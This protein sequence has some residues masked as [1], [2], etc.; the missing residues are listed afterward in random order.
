MSLAQEK[1]PTD[2]IVWQFPTENRFLLE[3]KPE[4]FFQPTISRRLKSGMF[5]FVRTSDPEPARIFE[6]FH[7]GIDIKPLH[8]DDK[9]EPLDV[10]RAVADGVVVRVNEDEK[11]SDYGRQVIVKHLWGEQPV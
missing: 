10:V 9:G 7:K 2:R 1:P 3:E 6:R 4:K 5:G 11:I 8:R